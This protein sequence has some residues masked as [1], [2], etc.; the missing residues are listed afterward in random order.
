VD[1]RDLVINLHCFASS[2]DA[3]DY[4]YQGLTGCFNPANHLEGKVEAVGLC[5]AVD[6]GDRLSHAWPKRRKSYCL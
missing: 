3:V 4:S 2:H 5:V 1:A 6:L